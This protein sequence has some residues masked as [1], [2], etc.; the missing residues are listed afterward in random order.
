MTCPD[1]SKQ[2]Y[3]NFIIPKI[4]IYEKPENIFTEPIKFSAGQ[5]SSNKQIINTLA[6]K[7]LTPLI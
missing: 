3:A 6:S 4:D 5:S 7:C 1:V 2:H